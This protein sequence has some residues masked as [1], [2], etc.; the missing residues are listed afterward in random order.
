MSIYDLAKKWRLEF[1]CIS[2]DGLI[3]IANVIILFILSVYWYG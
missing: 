1:G 2:I 3:D